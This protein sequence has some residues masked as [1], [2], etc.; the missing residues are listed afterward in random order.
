VIPNNDQVTRSDI[1][2]ALSGTYTIASISGDY[3]SFTEALVH[4][5]SG[6]I[7]ATT[8]FNVNTGTYYE[9]FEIP[10]ISG[11][12]ESNTIT[13]KSQSGNKQD[14]K[15][16][17]D[18]PSN[19]N[20]LVNMN[21]GSYVHFENMTFEALNNFYGIVF[22]FANGA[23]N[24][25]LSGNILRNN[26]YIYNSTTRSLI[27][28]NSSI[29]NNNE[30]S[31]NDF[32]NGTYGFYYFGT[33]SSNRES[34]TKILNNTFT[35]QYSRAISLQNQEDAIIRGN[36]ITSAS[37]LTNQYGIYCA[38]IFGQSEI[39]QN[40]ISMPSGRY[41]IYLASSGNITTQGRLFNNFIYVGGTTDVYGIY[42][43]GTN[44][45]GVSFNSV[46]VTSSNSSSSGMYL[47]G[48]SNNVLKNNIFSNSGTGYAYYINST[49]GISETNFNNLHVAQSPLAYWT[50][51]R[52]N[53][54]ELRDASSQEA[55]SLSVNPGFKSNDDLH[56]FDVALKGKGTPITGITIDIDGDARNATTPDIG[57]DEFVPSSLDI[58]VIALN[59]PSVPFLHGNNT[60]NVTFRNYGSN[61]ISS[62]RINWEVNGV[63]QTAYNWTGILAS[64]NDV[65]VDIGSFLF[66]VG[67]PY[68]LKIWT[69]L[70]NNS[71]DGQSLNDTI[72]IANLYAGLQGSY[73]IATEGADFS[74]FSS[75]VTTLNN[76]GITGSVTFNVADGTYAEQF[77]IAGFPGNDCETAVIFQS[78]SSDSSKVI[79]E[80]NSGSTANYTVM[81]DGASGIT[82]K[83]LTI[84]SLNTT[85]GTVVD[86]RNGARCNT[87]TNNALIAL[88]TN[89]TSTARSVI[90]SP[91][92][93][94]NNHNDNNNTIAN[95]L[96]EGGAYGLY[97]LG[98]STGNTNRETGNVIEGNIFRNQHY[99]GLSVYYQEGIQLKS[100]RIETNSSRNDFYG[101]YLYYCY[102]GN[103]I[104]ANNISAQNG[105]YGISFYSFNPLGQETI[106]ANNFIR[107]GGANTAY[108][109]AGYSS[110]YNKVVFNTIS[111]TSSNLTQG[112]G[113]YIS[114]GNNYTL[115]NNIFSNTG[116]GRAVYISN[117]NT[118][119]QIN[120]NNYHVTGNELGFLNG[121][122]SNFEA[123]KT[124]SGQ[125]LNS[126]NINPAFVSDIDLHIREVALY[127]AGTPVTEITTDIDGDLRNASNPGIGADEI[128]PSDDDAGI[129]AIKSP[130][131]PFKAGN[132]PVIIELRNYGENN[133]TSVAI[134][135]KINDV[136][137]T[138]FN[139]TGNL[140]KGQ[141]ADVTIGNFNFA[142][143]GV[144]DIEIILSSPN[145]ST[146]GDLTNNSI[147]AIQ[148][149]TGM[150][151]TYTIGGLN[152]DFETIALAVQQLE[153]GGAAE[154]VTFNLRAGTYEEQVL[155]GNRAGDPCEIP[156]IF[157][158]ETLDAESVIIQN[159]S[160]AAANYTLRLDN[161]SG[162]TFRHLTL[163][164]TNNTYGIVIDLRNGASC[165]IFENNKIIGVNVNTTADSRALVYS[166]SG[167]HYSL[168]DNNNVFENNHFLNGSF[169][170]FMQGVGTTAIDME[171]GLVI[172]GNTFE[173][174]YYTAM[175]LYFQENVQIE[176]NL[177]TTNKGYSSYYGIYTYYSREKLFIQKNNIQIQSGGGY[178]LY[179]YVST[180]TADNKTQ[181]AN[182]FISINGTSNAYGI[183]LQSSA[184]CNLYFNSVLLG[185]SVGASSRTLFSSSGSNQFYYNN[186]FANRGPGVA[187]YI[188][189]TNAVQGSNN[190]N[191]FAPNGILAYWSGN[192][193]TLEALQTASGYDSNSFAVDPLFVSEHD[194]HV[195][196][197]ILNGSGLSIE[198]ITEDI[199][200]NERGTPPDIGADEFTPSGTNAGLLAVQYPE[201]PFEPGQHPLSITFENKGATNL[202]SLTLNWEVNGQAQTAV[203]WTGELSTGNSVST[204]LGNFTFLDAIKYDLK[205]WLS[206]PNGS[207]DIDNS[208]D[209]LRVNNVFSA[210]AGSYAVGGINPVFASPADA[211]LALNSGGIRSAV[212]F[213]IADGTYEQQLNIHA[214]PGNSCDTQV[215]FKSVSEDSSKVVISHNS[216]SGNNFVVQ[217]NG[218][219]GVVLRDLTLQSLNTSYG[220]VISMLNGASCNL[221]TNNHLLGPSPNS[222]STARA[223]IHSPSGSNASHNSN[224]NII[225]NNLIENGS[226]GM[227]YLAYSTS[228]G[229]RETGT[230]I[231]NNI[232]KNQHYM[233]IQL[234]YQESFLLEGNTIVTNSS[235][236]DFYG[237]YVY[238]SYSGNKILRNIIRTTNG[239]YGMFMY[240]LSGTAGDEALIANNFVNLGGT[241][242]A[243]G[244]SLN[245]GAYNQVYHNTVKINSTDVNNGRSIYT[246]GG[247]NVSIVNNI[248]TNSGGGYSIY[249]NS[250]NAIDQMDYNNYYTTGPN[251][252]YWTASRSNLSAWQS[253]SG[254]DGNSLSV[255]PSF[256]D[257]EEG[258]RIGNVDLSRAGT[259]L[260]A[261]LNDIDG[262]VRSSDSPTIGADEISTTTADAGLLAFTS[263]SI[264]FLA[265]NSPITVTL[266][267]NAGTSLS[268]VKIDW[269]I[270][271]NLQTPFNWT[272]SVAPGNTLDVNIG[273]FNFQAGTVYNLK[274]WTS[275]PNGEDDQLKTNDT[276]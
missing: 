260:D 57:A 198:G 37:A 213:S 75:A 76:G 248:F 20:Y 122:I 3:G 244:I 234:Y 49:G 11:A 2:P 96:I 33:S 202:T 124:A 210:L 221:L 209:T 111:I 60:L 138:I 173:N 262:Q 185:A 259:P 130:V 169:G 16:S 103:R 172:K 177:I 144:Y 74:S 105:G 218:A 222:T 276:I 86:L 78:A 220:T 231:E 182:N 227:Y 99:M 145:G 149:N 267:N 257:D 126:L 133:L 266:L 14:V 36:E 200:G 79:L 104:E 140:S 159:S 62:A 12:S 193:T 67:E 167:N 272:G 143:G 191:F 190:N 89:S 87:F 34:G 175:F 271:G 112:V 147:T 27:Y 55:N 51:N 171:K 174:Q 275:A 81:I 233:G 13:F 45:F 237:L 217:L 50:A 228:A 125:D 30:F 242:T 187:F 59:D 52:A 252:G 28:S 134:N 155:I 180:S 127:G 238:Y 115:L 215:I 92:G 77:R 29:D 123:W 69:S 107:L 270:N 162:I 117:I 4:L 250:T 31:G 249:V 1:L 17:F 40:K 25:I 194:L 141:A 23:S 186:I 95:N 223:I 70:P 161:A 56:V 66:Q 196:S 137:Q 183:Y 256:I 179:I 22:E 106:I 119:A 113:L 195:N 21:G 243:H 216:G 54:A 63:A 226:Y 93:S 189:S 47:T 269:Q 101:I 240:V 7:S 235:R 84:K 39:S 102:N 263:P 211:V 32:I 5:K 197:A 164:A 152:P 153:K 83:N 241:G 192:R 214:F 246:I 10:A 142:F 18:A 224:D 203:N 158:S 184:H 166:P 64:G 247:N 136:S 150:A 199:D 61:S 148:Q 100:N 114:G 135:W 26:E 139:W 116:G 110:T 82:F 68:N 154:A 251:L 188:N 265:G 90:N 15:I 170:I 151:G 109:I 71:T 225:R 274:A 9:Q 80:S 261:V 254:K 204:A 258:F 268:S 219:R 176:E 19:A 131:M 41:G 35:N 44:N 73:T 212:T 85:Y 208:D 98:Y 24:N 146:D 245:Y 205:V 118:V 120:H 232:F 97:I 160:T 207:L 273:N 264:P 206:E 42:F 163:Q 156:V 46:H 239:G 58:G 108:G 132:Q 229:T 181:I 128:V 178:G 88:T 157:Q 91:S 236:N 38:G 72:S 253:A 53:L 168:L 65:A 94:N 255:N 6:G 43:T 165:N 8:T 201:A 129:V 121:A 48:G 230:V